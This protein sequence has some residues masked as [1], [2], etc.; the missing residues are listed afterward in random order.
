MA[1][2]RERKSI[3]IDD[4][5]AGITPLNILIGDLRLGQ[6]DAHFRGFSH[7]GIGS[8]VTAHS[9]IKLYRTMRQVE[10]RLYYCDTD[11]IITSASLPISKRLG[12]LKLEDSTNRACFLLPKTYI[13]GKSVKMKG[14][15]KEFA[16]SR[17]FT[18]FKIAMEGDLRSMKTPMPG[19][20]S[21]I[22]SAKNN[23]GSILKVMN[24]SVRQLRSTYDKRILFLENG[25]WNSRPVD[26]TQI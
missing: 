3:C 10:S 13:F 9:R 19:K 12:E 11:S 23:N 4:G 5:S 22:R 20:L 1:I 17:N 24:D 21:R 8:L 26:A 25:E 7:A 2:K 15:P 18:D 6:K 16:Q 14:F